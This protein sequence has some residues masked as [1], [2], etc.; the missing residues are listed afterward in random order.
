MAKPRMS[1]QCDTAREVEDRYRSL[2]AGWAREQEIGSELYW[3]DCE[4]RYQLRK[5]EAANG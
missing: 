3:M 2:V 4:D 5:K 1:R